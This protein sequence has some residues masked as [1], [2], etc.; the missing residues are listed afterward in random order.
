MSTPTPDPA[1]VARAVHDLGRGQWGQPD[2]VIPDLPDA[3][4]S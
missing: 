4:E 2:T 1:D 3:S